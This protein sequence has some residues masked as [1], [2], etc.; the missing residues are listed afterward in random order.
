[1]ARLFYIV[2]GPEVTK[3]DI[4]SCLPAEHEN[5]HGGENVIA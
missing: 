2:L 4:I 1:M 3:S 5:Y